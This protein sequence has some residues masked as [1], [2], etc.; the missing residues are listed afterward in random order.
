MA[1][2][3]ALNVPNCANVQ[4]STAEWSCVTL[5]HGLIGARNFEK[6]NVAPSS[7]TVLRV[8][9]RIILLGRRW[10]SQE[11]LPP[12]RPTQITHWRSSICQQPESSTP[13]YSG[14]VDISCQ[15]WLHFRMAFNGLAAQSS[16]T[17]KSA[18]ETMTQLVLH[19]ATALSS[20]QIRI[21]SYFLFH[22]SETCFSHV[23]TEHSTVRTIPTSRLPPP[24]LNS[25]VSISAWH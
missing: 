8:S 6:K 17:L 18:R 16:K 1:I 19:A 9:G 14:C 22:T 2:A 23:W 25:A 12:K 7:S 3:T 5:R 4:V 11:Y 20:L 15:L 24:K 13:C 21:Q 10:M